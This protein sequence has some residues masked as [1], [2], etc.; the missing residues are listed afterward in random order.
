MMG[1]RKGSSEVGG[2]RC[3]CTDCAPLLLGGLGREENGRLVEGQGGGA[4][5]QDVLAPMYRRER[6]GGFISGLWHMEYGAWEWHM[7]GLAW[8]DNT[9]R[10]NSIALYKSVVGGRMGSVTSL[11]YSNRREQ[12]SIEPV[13]LLIR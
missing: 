3:G 6:V 2:V 5:Q 10:K 12:I 8:D 4:V 11:Q 13:L 9:R 7:G 1:R